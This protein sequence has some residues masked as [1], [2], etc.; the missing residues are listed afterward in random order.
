MA[1]RNES[2]N[3]VNMAVEMGILSDVIRPDGT[4]IKL[5]VPRHRSNMLEL[6]L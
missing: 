6:V 1:Y 2:E 5:T 4:T 3:F